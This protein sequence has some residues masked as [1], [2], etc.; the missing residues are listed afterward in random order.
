[1]ASAVEVYTSSVTTALD[2]GLVAPFAVVSAVLLLRGSPAGYVS[3]ALLLVLNVA[4]GTALITQGAAQLLAGV[5]LTVGEIVGKSLSFAAL[6]LVAGGL[7]ASLLGHHR[8]RT[9][10]SH[11]KPGSGGGHDDV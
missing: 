1:I 7:V 11:T 3:S 6:T 9:A 5:P 2:L 10:L 8:R 4:I